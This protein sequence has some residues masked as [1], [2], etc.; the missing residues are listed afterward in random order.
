MPLQSKIK[1][2]FIGFIEISSDEALDRLR[3]ASAGILLILP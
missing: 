2:P 1:P 3:R